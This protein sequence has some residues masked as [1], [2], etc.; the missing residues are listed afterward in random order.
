MKRKKRLE[1]G[2]ESLKERIKEHE[3]KLQE[4]IEEDR[5]D[6]IS[7]FSKEITNLKK[8]EEKKKKQAGDRN[9]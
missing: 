5:E 3:I 8:I 6:L 9:P 2:I 1:K 4:A 7:Y